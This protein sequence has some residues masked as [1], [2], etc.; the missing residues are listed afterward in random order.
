M[1]MI[2]QGGVDQDVLLLPKRKDQIMSQREFVHWL[3]E[4][5]DKG[6][7]YFIFKNWNAYKQ[8]VMEFRRP[9]SYAGFRRAIW[10]MKDDGFLIALPKA[11]PKDKRDELF[12]TTYYR[13]S[14]R[15]REM[16]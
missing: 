9:C 8:F 14:P 1:I 3:L 16:V 4:R 12:G 11:A 2:L 10:K 5:H 7:P 13:L 15:A 6:T